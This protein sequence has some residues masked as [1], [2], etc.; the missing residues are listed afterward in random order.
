MLHQA[1]TNHGHFDRSLALLLMAAGLFLRGGHSHAE[2]PPSQPFALLVVGPDGR[3]IQGQVELRGS[4]LLTAEQITRGKFLRKANYGTFVETDAEGRLA[5]NRPENVRNFAAS[6]SI[7][8]Y[9]PYW[10]GWSSGENSEPIPAEFT[11]QLDAGWSVGGI[12][13]D[14]DGEPVVGASV[15]PS[16]R[17]KKRA[18]DQKDLYTGAT[19]KTDA[20]GQWRYDCV[21]DSA[22]DVSVEINHNAYKSL[23][24]RL[25]RPQFGLTLVDQPFEII[26]LDRGLSVIGK[27]TDTDGKPI[28]GATIR[29]KFLND[30]RE[31]ITDDMG[32]YRLSGC[33]PDQ[34]RIVV[35]AKGKATDMREV[36]I[37]PDMEP[38]DFIMSPGGTVRIRV[39]DE[40]DRPVPKARIFFQDWRGRFQYFE[41]NHINQYADENGVWVWNEAPLDGFQADICPPNGMQLGHQ[42]LVARDEEFVFRTP[43]ALVI[44]GKVIDAETKEPIKKF[45]VIPG[46]R[47]PDSSMH[48]SRSEQFAS[49]D[50]QY[51]LRHVH[52]RDAHLVRIEAE[53]YQP[54]VSRDIKN[55]EGMVTIDFALRKGTDLAATVLTPDG[56]PAKEARVALGVAGSQI[57]IKNGEIDYRQTYCARRETT[58][59]GRFQFPPEEGAF[60]IIITHPS[61]YMYLEATAETFPATI[62]LNAWAQ[63]EGTFRLGKEPAGNV[64]LSLNPQGLD[65]YGKGLPRVSTYYEI[66]TDEQGNFAFDRVVPGPARIG[67]SILLMVNEGARDVA[68]CSMI[69]IDLPSGKLTRLKLG[70]TGR[71]VIAQLE[72]PPG[73]KEKIAWPFAHVSASLYRPALPMAN[74]PQVPPDIRMDVAKRELW[75]LQWQQTPEG[76][77]WTAYLA[78]V[79]EQQRQSDAEPYHWATVDRTGKVRLE[80]LPAGDYTLSVGFNENRPGGKLHGYRFTI[81]AISEP[82]ADEPLDLG[83]LTLE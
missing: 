80:D 41:F 70:G 68:S 69:P 14:E 34:V 55:N 51:H 79:Q 71:A 23:R 18:G 43:P 57:M 53:G 45:Q 76:R 13:V 64:K 19:I 38:L 8:G 31:T 46:L 62:K 21:P 83:V 78:A 58:E 16:V 9:A 15:H 6:I 65:S 72:P 59:A 36:R 22:Q 12:V 82:R 35:F 20:Q 63:I 67:R 73:Q 77:A 48:W 29:T 66:P 1:V 74:P 56:Q 39:V 2:E 24:Q 54:A 26:V 60:Q 50:G 27:V 37:D 75:M 33:S 7:P 17:F 40:Q 47:W 44:T 4:P 42:P 10:A 28:V 30:L 49:V 61:G 52:D 11:A 32:Q 5:V 25:A 3:P 81:P